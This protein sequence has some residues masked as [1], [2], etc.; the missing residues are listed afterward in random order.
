MQQSIY[1]EGKEY[2]SYSAID[3]WQHN[4]AQYR[5]RYYEGVKTP[6]TVYTSYGRQVH[7]DIE[8]GIIKIDGFKTFT[9]EVMIRHSIAG[10]DMLA[11]VDLLDTTTYTFADVKTSKH[12][13]DVVRVQ[14]LNQLP[15]YSLLIQDAYGEVQNECAVVWVETLEK[16]PTAKLDGARCPLALQRTGRV[17]TIWRSIEQAERDKWRDIIISTADEIR[18]DFIEYKTTL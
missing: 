8:N 12:E 9:S 10:V 2:L 3:L 7:Q 17:E 13:W 4:R 6:D 11:Y 5:K 18:K 14:K 16:T 1:G 15:V